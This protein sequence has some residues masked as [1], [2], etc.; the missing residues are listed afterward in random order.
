M[1]L[2]VFQLKNKGSIVKSK[3][4]EEEF[5]KHE[6]DNITKYQKLGYTTNYIFR[7]G[8]LVDSISK[9]SFSPGEVHIVAEHRY[10]G[11][12]NPSD[13]SILYIIK[14]DDGGKGN[15]LM[16]YGPTAD[17]DVADFFKAIP[18]DNNSNQENINN[19]TS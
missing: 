8:K 13:M 18:E 14:T 15:F 19:K 3:N 7:K 12:S 2:S 10:E 16:A 17:M 11:M 5:S 9:K 1:D 4:M 6:I